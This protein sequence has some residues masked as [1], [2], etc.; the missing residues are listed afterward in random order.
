MPN[1]GLLEVFESPGE[2]PYV[3]EH[4]AEEFTS[5]CPV[6]GHPDFG[7]VTVRYR[8]RPRREGGACVELKSLKLYYQSFRSE[9]IFYEAVTNLIRDDLVRLMRPAWLQVRTDWRGRGG[10]RSVIRADHGDVPEE[11][12]GK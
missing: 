11:Y 6:T 10:I 8:P 7:T 1:A 9:G 4:V 5:L 3:I 12:R 2:E